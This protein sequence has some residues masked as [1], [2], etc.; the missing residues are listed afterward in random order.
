MMVYSACPFKLPFIPCV[1]LLE[2]TIGSRGQWSGHDKRTD[3][4]R[5]RDA[6][7]KVSEL[8]KTYPSGCVCDAVI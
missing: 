8:L 3:E 4:K 1:F 5:H 7:G 6:P 2:N